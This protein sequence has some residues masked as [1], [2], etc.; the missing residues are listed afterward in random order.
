MF[1][2][3]YNRE[4]SVASEQRHKEYSCYDKLLSIFHKRTENNE[5]ANDH[6]VSPGP[7][8]DDRER[9][10]AAHNVE[11]SDI[12]NPEESDI[13][14]TDGIR[15]LYLGARLETHTNPEQH[16]LLKC[17]HILK[18]S[19]DT[20]VAKQMK[21]KNGDELLILN[22]IFVPVLT[23]RE[24]LEL[25]LSTSVDR[26][27]TNKLVVRRRKRDNKWKWY[28]LSSILSPLTQKDIGVNVTKQKCNKVKELKRELPESSHVYKIPGSQLYLVIDDTGL[29]TET[30]SGEDSDRTKVIQK[31][32][33][34]CEHGDGEI[35]F[36]V[37][38]RDKA[39]SR[40]ISINTGN[41]EIFLTGDPQWLQM[42]KIGNGTHFMTEG[43]YLGYDHQ[44]DRVKPQRSKYMFE[45]YPPPEHL[46]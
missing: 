25:F 45:E 12:A 7:G 21:I 33:I 19:G 40:Y 4:Q 46:N 8:I 44:E 9:I 23:N 18:L 17:Q 10:P 30:L 20:R 1:R 24:V 3:T 37:A 43:F 16:V 13:L 29:R 14:I 2:S 26:Q 34:M 38:L 35:H 28:E 22:G 31:R 36:E 5:D 42:S 6:D 39:M 15:N 27:S 11:D 41:E 32:M